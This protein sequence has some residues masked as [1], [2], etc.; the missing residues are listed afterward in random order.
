MTFLDLT[1]PTLEANLA[2]DEAL[3]LLAEDHGGETLRTW[4][5][6]VPAVVLGA[7]GILTE[8]VNED[9]CK[10]DSVPVL[11]RS[12]GGGTVLLGHGCLCFSLMLAY[13]R[14]SELALVPSSYRYILSLISKALAAQVPGIEPAGTSDL[15]WLGRKVSGNSQQR[16]RRHLLH[17]GTLL[18]DFDVD[19]VGR[20]LRQPSRQ[21][22]YRKQRLHGE[23][24]A[25]L[26]IGAEE[27]KRCLCAIWDAKQLVS[28]EHEE[29]V[30][31]LVAEKYSRKEWIRR[32]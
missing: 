17:H 32:R 10:R 11:R 26:P 21:P 4:E 22:E 3:L 9:A 25:K 2:L 5:W 24:L 30:Q 12:S 19:L 1:L 18:Y 23:F 8:D 6:T 29:T 16:K 28:V 13:D 27:L 15:A 14:A 7:A 31:K 20:Y